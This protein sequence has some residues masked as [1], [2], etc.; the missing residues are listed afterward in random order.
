MTAVSAKGALCAE[1]HALSRRLKLSPQFTQTCMEKG[2]QKQLAFIR[3]LFTDEVCQR[4]QNKTNRL[5]KRAGFPALKTFDEYE[6]DRVSFP[7][8]LTLEDICEGTFIDERLNLIFF[9]PVGTGKTH[10][11]VAAGIAACRRGRVVRFFTVAA[12]VRLLSQSMKDGKLDGLIRDLQKCDLLILD[13]WGYVPVDRDGAR[14]LFQIISDSY[15]SRSLILTTNLEF[16]RW[17]SVMADEQMAAA[18]IDR[19]VHHGHLLAFE[20]QSYRMEHALMRKVPQQAA[21]TK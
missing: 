16:S 15:E 3:D 2:S 7:E 11:A 9:G 21:G 6:T 5:L 17:G 10:M 1:I 4:D 13:E 14:L 20:G 12:L 8:G 18:M 19:L